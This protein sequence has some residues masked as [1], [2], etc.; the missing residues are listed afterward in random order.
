MLGR[1]MG[2]NF[3]QKGIRL[4]GNQF[5]DFLNR[6]SDI[7]FKEILFVK[8]NG[9][10]IGVDRLDKTEWEGQDVYLQLVFKRE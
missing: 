9:K 1:E 5:K 2:P 3:L 10:K 4:E 8:I 6:Q 7:F